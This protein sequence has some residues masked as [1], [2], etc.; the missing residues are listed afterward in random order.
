VSGNWGPYSVGAWLDRSQYFFNTDD[1]TVTGALAAHHP[2]P[3]RTN[4]GDV[5]GLLR[6]HGEYAA[7]VRQTI[8][9]TSN[10]DSG[11]QRGRRHADRAVSVAQVP[12]LHRELFARLAVH[13]VERE[14]K[15]R[16]GPA[17]CPDNQPQLLRS[18][19][20]HRRP[21]DEPIWNTPDSGYAEKIK[22]TVEPWVNLQ[23]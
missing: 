5:A 4:A 9:G 11:L 2:E 10:Y 19:G 17:G 14:P 12:V 1:S 7:M 18:P 13:V 16:H 3:G 21:G 23:R 8:S 6:R 15:P 20:P 22:H